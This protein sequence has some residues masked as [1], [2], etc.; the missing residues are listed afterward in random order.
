MT[1]PSYH[2][3]IG[4]DVQV[5]YH[6]ETNASTKGEKTPV[7]SNAVENQMVH[8]VHSS[9]KFRERWKYSDYSHCIIN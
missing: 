4:I 9:E 6:S 2:A 3:K 7:N 1:K 8:A 5:T